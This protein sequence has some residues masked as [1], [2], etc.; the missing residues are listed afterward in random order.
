MNVGIN[1]KN[2]LFADNNRSANFKTIK[3]NLPKGNWKIMSID[4]NLV[5]LKGKHENTN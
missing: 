1:V 5:T 3:H 4:N 2:Q